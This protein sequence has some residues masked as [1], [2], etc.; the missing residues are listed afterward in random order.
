MGINKFNAGPIEIIAELI[1]FD[2]VQI[3]N[4]HIA[5]TPPCRRPKRQKA[6]RLHTRKTN[7]RHRGPNG[8]LFYEETL[9]PKP[10]PSA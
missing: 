10:K 3:K 7:R 9:W 5:Y 6:I 1:D 4:E 8:P 2:A